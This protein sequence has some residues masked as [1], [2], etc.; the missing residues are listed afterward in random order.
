M[1][2]NAVLQSDGSSSNQMV[3]MCNQ[4]VKISI[5][6]PLLIKMPKAF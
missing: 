2:I 5:T 3:L 4:M 1:Y 6:F